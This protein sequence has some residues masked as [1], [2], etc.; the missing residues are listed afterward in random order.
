[1]VTAASLGF[2]PPTLC[3]ARLTLFITLQ[4]ICFPPLTGLE[5]QRDAKRNAEKTVEGPLTVLKLIPSIITPPHGDKVRSS[6]YDG[7]PK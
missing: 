2:P 1:L 3:T 5:V 6:K 4:E 7:V